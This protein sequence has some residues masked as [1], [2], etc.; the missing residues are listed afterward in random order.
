M[1]HRHGDHVNYEWQSSWCGDGKL[2]LTTIFEADLT[3]TTH[4]DQLI[5]DEEAPV[6]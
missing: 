5:V 2:L 1:Q 4:L 6:S 3:H